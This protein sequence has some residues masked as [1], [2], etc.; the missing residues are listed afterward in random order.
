MT[1]TLYHGSDVAV[2]QPLA[3]VGRHNLDFGLGF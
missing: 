1:I 2:P 3:K